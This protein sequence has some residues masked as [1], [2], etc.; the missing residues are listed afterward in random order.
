MKDEKILNALEKVDEKFITASSPENTKKTKNNK[1]NAWVKWGS[2][3]ACFALLVLGIPMVTHLSPATDDKTPSVELS[4]IENNNKVE[5]L[6]H[7]KEEASNIPEDLSGDSELQSRIEELS[8]ADSLGWI[9]YDNRIYIQDLNTDNIGLE[10]NQNNI[11]LS[12]CLGKASD[13]KGAYQ[14]QIA[15]SCDGNVFLVADN[16]DILCI[17]LDD[18]STVWLGAEGTTNLN[19]IED[20]EDVPADSKGEYNEAVNSSDLTPNTSEFFGGSYTDANGKFVIVLTEDTAENRT[21]ICKE[22]DKSE[23]NTTFVKGTYTLAYLTELQTKIT[24]AMVNKELPF[25]VTSGVYET[26]NNIVIRVTTNDEAELAKVYALDTIGGAIKVEF[27]AGAE[28]KDL[29]LPLPKA[30]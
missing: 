15:D 9:V 27:S 26:T 11:E 19:Y 24:N 7:N 2:I 29:L 16:S 22:L 25:V 10:S 18:G 30:E 12:E 23:S 6:Q 5:N 3:A 20:R 8:L 1:I 17:K 28:T 4:L 14:N 21:A 13:Y